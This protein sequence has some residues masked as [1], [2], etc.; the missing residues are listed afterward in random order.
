MF[1]FRPV[2]LLAAL[3]LMLPLG[4]AFH[5]SEGRSVFPSYAVAQEAGQTT[6]PNKEEYKQRR[7]E[8]FR[9]ALDL[10]PEQAS[11][12]DQIRAEANQAKASK[13]DTMRAAHDKMKALMASDASDSELLAQHQVIQGLHQEMSDARFQTMLAIRKELTPVQRTK[14]AELK[15][16]HHGRRGRHHGQTE[17]VQP[18]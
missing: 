3:P 4:S 7:Q 12:I 16:Q 13:R 1:K 9:K 18:E 8:E 15:E 17:N 11:K 10:T 6:K 5:L 2:H 14:M